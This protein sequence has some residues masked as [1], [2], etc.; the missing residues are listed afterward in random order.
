MIKLVNESNKLSDFRGNSRGR[1]GTKVR[2]K[3]TGEIGYVDSV[4]DN[5]WSHGIKVMPIGKGTYPDF[6]RVDE[7]EIL[8][9]MEDEISGYNLDPEEL[10][11]SDDTKLLIIADGRQKE[12]PSYQFDSYAKKYGYASYNLSFKY[13]GTMPDLIYTKTN[14]YEVDISGSP[15]YKDAVKAVRSICESV[16]GT[17]SYNLCAYEEDVVSA[18]TELKKESLGNDF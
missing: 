18:Y 13:I 4:V 12:V 1:S 17:Y 2:V 5:K 9:G 7:V 14:C 11:E 16:F 10:T 15:S 6:Y 3:A 8:E